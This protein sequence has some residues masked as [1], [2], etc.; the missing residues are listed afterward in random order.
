MDDVKGSDRKIDLF[1]LLLLTR[2]PFGKHTM[3]RLH[4]IIDYPHN[5]VSSSHFSF[6]IATLLSESYIFSLF[7]ALSFLSPPRPLRPTH[8]PQIH[9]HKDHSAKHL[10]SLSLSVSLSVPHTGTLFIYLSHPP[11]PRTA[12]LP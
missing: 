5:C 9:T 6:A 12:P 7:N 1:W 11:G 3:A 10:I 8:S 2:S 4:S